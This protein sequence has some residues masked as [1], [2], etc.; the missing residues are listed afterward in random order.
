VGVVVDGCWVLLFL[1]ST[2]GYF[3]KNIFVGYFLVFLIGIKLYYCL[4]YR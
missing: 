3:G 4:V 1:V 2:G